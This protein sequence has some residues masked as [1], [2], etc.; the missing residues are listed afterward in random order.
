MPRERE[1]ESPEDEKAKVPLA[2]E[3]RRG[4][5]I[6]PFDSD[7]PMVR[8]VLVS[9]S[10][11]LAEHLTAF[12]RQMAGDEVRIDV[13]AGTGEDRSEFGT[14]ATA[15]AET[16][17]NGPTGDGVVV[18]VDVGSAVMSAEM[19]LEFLD[20]DVRDRVRLSS[21]P[22]VE[23]T[24][25]A[26][27]QASLGNDLDTVCREADTAL[28]Q[29]LQA[30]ER[31]LPSSPPATSDPP[32]PDAPPADTGDGGDS[33]DASGTSPAVTATVVLPN[34][35]GLHA[36]P[37]AQFVR[38]AAEFDAEVTAENLTRGRGPVS[39]SSISG[40]SQLGAVRDHEIRLHATGP[41]AASAIEQ[42]KALI[43]DGFGEIDG[44]D[45]DRAASSSD[46]DPGGP[47]DGSPNGP[48]NGRREASATSARPIVPGLALGP[49]FVYR[50]SLPD[51]PEEPSGSPEEEWNRVASAITAVREALDDE[52]AAHQS[53]G[54]GDAAGILDAHIL[55]LEDPTL[56]RAVRRDVLDDHRP[57]ARAWLD[58]IDAV[59]EEYAMMEDAYLADRAADVRDVGRRVA[60]EILGAPPTDVGGPDEP[61]VLFASTLVPSDVHALPER[62]CG[63]ACAGGNPSSHAAI[64]LRSRGIP[65]V[66]DAGPSI[67]EV[68]DGT[69][70]GIDGD[71]GRVWIDV[72][73]DL[74]DQLKVQLQEQ[75]DR[76][77]ALRRE[78]QAP[79][80]T[81]DGTE[82][83]VSANVNA[84]GDAGAARENGSDGVGLL[85][86]EFLFLD[87]EEPPSEDDQ[88]DHLTTVAQAMEGRPVTVRALD[89]G[90]DKP[91]RF[92]SLPK[93]SNPFLGLRGIRV[94]LRHP[95]L[96][97]TQLRA[98]LRVAAE[99]PIRLLLP[100]VATAEEVRRAREMLDDARA[101]LEREGRAVP[102]SL[103]L[104][105]MIETPASAVAARSLAEVA[106]FFSI[107]TNDLTQYTMAADREHGDLAELADALH[108]PVLH[109][110][111]Q[112]AG[113]AEPAGCPVSICGEI[114]ADIFAVPILVGLGIRHLSIAPPSVPRI[115]AAVRGLSLDDT[116]SLAA[117]A[118][119]ADDA[120]AVRAISRAYWN[121]TDLSFLS[122]HPVF[123]G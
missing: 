75:H 98:V 41:E 61:F 97:R 33:P 32:A 68:E 121:G 11:S 47:P 15:I 49:S 113:A 80:S 3:K 16:I 27:V 28:Q 115:K 71:E 42:L 105:V 117:E 56:V 111:R 13:A 21:A 74:A 88:V 19:A 25:S 96:F 36:R 23:G 38:T 7:V 78:A 102:E 83:T 18:L 53:A 59:A 44:E 89:V 54:S 103:S 46:A 24:L 62:V 60:R 99:H 92:V 66:F 120:A 94:L 22:F 95:D 110:I 65:A 76:D 52:R 93:E 12:V 104:G 45:A 87:R 101:E 34:E 20:D 108:P 26:A 119:E 6:P 109:L 30:A 91:L 107:G 123:S 43:E 31:R 122:T 70:V 118:L 58:A 57:A 64:L 9:H 112:V 90:G 79:P 48:A 81:K 50:P 55:L 37:A 69:R 67:L 4:L 2:A 40:V 1:P 5:R 82:V 14:D 86:T 116:Q 77:L 10:R 85:R 72:S 114:A 100:M 106:D 84:T 17:T 51:L 39:A 73:D 29:K 8:L 63:V 35:H